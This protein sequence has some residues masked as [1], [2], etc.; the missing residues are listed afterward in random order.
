MFTASHIRHSPR[1]L[2]ACGLA[3]A[4]AAFSMSSVAAAS[5]QDLRSP[6]SRDAAQSGEIPL[7]Q[8]LYGSSSPAPAPIDPPQAA[9]PSHDTRWLSIAISIAAMLVLAAAIAAQLRRKRIRRRR[10]AR[11]AA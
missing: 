11:V 8:K 7:A 10:A 1:S 6:D 4:L 3:C 2:I 9:A 5:S